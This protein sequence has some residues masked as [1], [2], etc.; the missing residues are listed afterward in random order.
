MKGAGSLLSSALGPL[1]LRDLGWCV[2]P[3]NTPIKSVSFAFALT[4]TL[5]EGEG[6]IQEAQIQAW[7]WVRAGP[8]LAFVPGTRTVKR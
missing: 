8:R 6:K 4:L 1:G 7:C 2:L 3:P 5:C